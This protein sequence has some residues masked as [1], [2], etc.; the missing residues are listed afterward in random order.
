MLTLGENGVM[1]CKSKDLSITHVSAEKVKAV[2]TTVGLCILQEIWR[3]VEL[4]L[5]FF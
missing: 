1:F 2:D 3:F 5:M 4:Y